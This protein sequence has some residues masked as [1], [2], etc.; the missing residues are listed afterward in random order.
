MT[1]YKGNHAGRLTL[2]AVLAALPAAPLAAQV[3][4]SGRIV[5]SVQD[6]SGAILPGVKVE[7]AGEK[8]MGV[9]VFTTDDRGEYRFGSLPPGTYELTF[10]FAGFGTT[11]RTDVRVR[12]G[13]IIE[14]NVRLKV[15][16][17][18]EG[19]TVEASE[20]V[21][22]TKGTEVETTFDRDWIENSP[23]QR[24]SFMDILTSAPGVEPGESQTRLQPASFGSNVDQNLYQLDGVDL[25]DH[26]NGNASTLVQPSIDTIEQVEILSLGAPAEYGW[27]EGAVFNVVT[28]QGTNKFSGGAAFYHQSDG[29]TGRNT[30][31]DFDGGNPF[32]RVKY[33]NFTAQL[34]GPIIK[35][36]LWFFTAYEH[37]RDSFA[38]PTV[39]K[40]Q[41][42]FEDLDHYLTKLSFQVKPGHQLTGVVNIDQQQEDFGRFPG[43]APETAEGTGRKTV[44]P[45][46][47]YTGA[48]SANTAV[49]GQYAGFFVSHDCCGAGGGKR[50]IGTRFENLD[51][52]G[53]SGAIFGW[54]SYDVSKTSVNAKVSH[55]ASK[56]LNAGHDF[57]FGVQYSNAPV[58]G[59]YGVNDRVYTSNYQS[60][61]GY[62]YTPYAYGGT[63]RAVGVFLDDSIQIGKRLQLNAGV[64]YDN[65]NARFT[66]QPVTDEVGEPTDAMVRG[67]DVYKWNTISPRFGFNLKLTKDAKTV[68][69]GHY[70][71]YYRAGN[72]GEWVAATSPTRVQSLFGDWNFQTSRFENVVVNGVPSNASVDPGLE[73]ARTD[74]FTLS[75][76]RELFPLVNVA[77]TFVVKRGRNLSNW[78]DAGGIYAPVPYVDDVGAE[79]SGRTLTVFQLQ[80]DRADRAFLL[81]TGRQT[82]ADVRALSL[83]ATRRMASNWQLTTSLTLQKATSV[84]VFGQTAQLNFREYGRDPNAYINSDGRAVRDRPVLAKVQFLHRG[85]PWGLSLGV[86]WNYYTGYPTRRE[87]RVE[88]TNL[89]SPVQTQPRTDDTRFPSV[90]L[91][92]LRLEKSVDVGKGARLTLLGSVFNTFNDDA[93]TN[94]RSDLAT[95]DI[96]HAPEQVLAPRRLMLGA[97]LDF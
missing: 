30:G 10:S 1:R 76:E 46:L 63:V 19:V 49:E 77:A 95:S 43:Q 37:L 96:Y 75:L 2:W 69:K 64:R 97:K 62:D 85:L 28:R 70:G 55:H 58:D 73:P 71:R 60:G 92:N 4:T 20:A 12:V 32:S 34:A 66:D 56:F 21:V 68:L 13:S 52:G 6:E 8:V 48:V 11:R 27:H 79:A 57:K 44:T 22:D 40:D 38:E 24:R 15:G 80:N 67:F 5:G 90:N 14:E 51:T 41:A 65:T 50:I 3:A 81:T 25:T 59:L 54:Y 23:N 9:Q 91:L 16:A 39:P 94:F 7:L 53:A 86:D 17:R 78:V 31:A 84:N 89:N 36:K 87:V 82:E 72:T 35:D 88:A 26:F 29:L 61:Y 18:A 93:V 45:S 42:G 33:A 74:Q 83:T 47:L